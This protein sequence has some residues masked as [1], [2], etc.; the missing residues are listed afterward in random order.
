M[1]QFGAQMSKLWLKLINFGSGGKTG[2][3]GLIWSSNGS[4]LGLNQSIW[5]L[6]GWSCAQMSPPRHKFALCLG[7][8]CQ[9]SPLSCPQSALTYLISV[10]SKTIAALS[11]PFEHQIDLLCPKLSYFVLKWACLEPMLASLSLLLAQFTSDWPNR[12]SSS[13]A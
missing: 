1:S 9:I 4:T 2:S 3:N 5:G 10:P 12:G 11:L 6:N 13:Q 7:P 8:S